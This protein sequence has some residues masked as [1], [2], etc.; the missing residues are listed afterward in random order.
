M[1]K[2]LILL[3]FILAGC[4]EGPEGP[5]GSTGPAGKDGE[6]LAIR[7]VKGTILS[8]NWTAGNPSHAAIYLCNCLS[9]PTV[10]FVGVEN[11]NGVFDNT[12][13][14]AVIYGTASSDYS[15]DGKTGYYALVYDNLKTNLQKNYKVRF[16]GT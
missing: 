12:A 6:D 7:E 3:A 5:R 14:A 2:W 11:S 16:V 4:I 10:L 1:G 8:K 13:W 15:Y 9:E